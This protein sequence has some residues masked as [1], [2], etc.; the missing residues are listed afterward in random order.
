MCTNC[1]TGAHAEPV[2]FL[3]IESIDT[4][5]VCTV[6]MG[7][8]KIASWLHQASSC[9]RVK[10][11]FGQHFAIGMHGSSCWRTWHATKVC[12]RTHICQDCAHNITIDLGLMV[13]AV[14]LGLGVS[15]AKSWT[16]KTFWSGGRLSCG[17]LRLLN[18]HAFK[19]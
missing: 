13:S 7:Q 16:P 14:D 10:W 3:P 5:S 12:I 11:P 17:C 15:W 4:T 1:D 18:S 9:F 8:N 2:P 19:C 6:L